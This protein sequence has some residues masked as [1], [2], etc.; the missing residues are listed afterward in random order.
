[1]LNLQNRGRLY[2]H[3]KA[4]S[5]KQCLDAQRRVSLELTSATPA[6]ST[7]TTTAAAATTSVR[8]HLTESRGNDLLCLLKNLDQVTSK[9]C[10]SI[11]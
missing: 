1:V 4:Q 2:H 9:F 7:T 8:N 11:V 6:A 5:V 10:H 3:E